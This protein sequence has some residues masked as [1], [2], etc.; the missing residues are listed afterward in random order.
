MDKD[1]FENLVCETVAN[2]SRF[3]CVEGYIDGVVQDYSISIANALD[4]L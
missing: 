2:L 1:G 4:I 3:E